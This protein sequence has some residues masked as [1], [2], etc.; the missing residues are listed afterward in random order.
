MFIRQQFSFDV[1]PLQLFTVVAVDGSL[2]HHSP[3]SVAAAMMVFLFGEA[4][5]PYMCGKS[6]SYPYRAV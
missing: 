2:A 5:E 1:Y 3:S 6:L 4:A